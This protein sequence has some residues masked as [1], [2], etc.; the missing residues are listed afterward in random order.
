MER[1]IF[2]AP[3]GAIPDISSVAYHLLTILVDGKEHPRDELCQELGG[4]FRAYLQQLGGEYYQHWLINSETK[5][6][7][8]RKQAH[9]QLDERHFICCWEQDKDARTIARKR[10]KDRSLKQAKDGLKRYEQASAEKREA[11][12]DYIERFEDG[13][14]DE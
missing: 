5:E 14:E 3:E 10:Y 8:G 11:D 7:K 2:S 1:L 12:Q 6:Y 4:G 13:G 9:Y